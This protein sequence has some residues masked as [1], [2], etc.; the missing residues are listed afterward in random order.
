MFL[1]LDGFSDRSIKKLLRDT[2]RITLGAE[3]KSPE[4]FHELDSVLL[5]EASDSYLNLLTVDDL[6]I[7]KTVDEVDE[8][9]IF[10]T[11]KLSD[12]S[13][14]PRLHNIHLHLAHINQSLQLRGEF[15]AL[16]QLGLLVG[17]PSVLV[18]GSTPEE[19]ARH[20]CGSDSFFPSL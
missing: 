3:K 16:H 5:H 7:K 18:R 6:V 11:K 4:L 15:L 2:T 19:S 20:L 1:K 17:E 9:F 10:E 13:R 12:S 14:N 8:D